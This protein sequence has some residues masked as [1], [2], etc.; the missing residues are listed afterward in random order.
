MLP[1]PPRPETDATAPAV[2]SGCGYKGSRSCSICAE[3]SAQSDS[4]L[5]W[6]LL[7]LLLLLLLLLLADS[8]SL[9]PELLQGSAE[10]PGALSAAMLSNQA[11]A[12]RRRFRCRAGRGGVG[13]SGGNSLP[14]PASMANLGRLCLGLNSVFERM[15]WLVGACQK[16]WDL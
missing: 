4:L 12:M 2:G 10:S 8:A 11:P 6:L 5:P 13:R 7:V 15:H 1:P 9:L 14:A 16:R 3:P